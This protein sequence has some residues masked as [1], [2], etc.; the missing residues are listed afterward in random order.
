MRAGFVGKTDIGLS[1]ERALREHN[2]R[3]KKILH[4]KKF[5]IVKKKYI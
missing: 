1:W 5:Y 2:A 4:K 3:K